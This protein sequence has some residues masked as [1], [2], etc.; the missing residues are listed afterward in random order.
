V[1]SP[2]PNSETARHARRPLEPDDVLAA[3]DDE[4]DALIRGLEVQQGEGRRLLRRP[5]RCAP[6][7]LAEVPSG[8]AV[9]D[10]R[11]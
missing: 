7:E 1:Y 3:A 11:P 5:A 2:A 6:E 10:S 9:V 8:L 4:T